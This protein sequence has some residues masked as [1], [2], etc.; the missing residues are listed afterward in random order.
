MNVLVVCEC[1]GVV[2]EAFRRRGHAAWSCDLKPAEDGSPY[3][4]T[5][6]G[7]RIA[8]RPGWDLVI[9]HP[10]CTYLCASGMH[11]TTRGLRD[12]KLTQDALEFV[13]ALWSLPAARVCIENPVGAI[14]GLLA[15]ATQYIQPY[16]FG[17]DASKRTGLWLRGLAPLRVDPRRYVRPRLV[18]R[19]CGHVIHPRNPVGWELAGAR[20]CPACG[21]DPDCWAHRWD[22]QTDSGQNR[23]GP[24]PERAA[25]RSRTYPGIA[26]AMAE[27]WG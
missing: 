19:P 25:D 12:P 24:G 11:W 1:S 23:L 22:N 9:A 5:G 4:H 18:C 21:A 17:D 27:Q 8:R 7:L 20:G 2:R 14:R 6:D 10:P 13:A 16:Q 3:H 26:K 15:P